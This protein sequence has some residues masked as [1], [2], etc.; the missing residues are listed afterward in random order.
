M[1]PQDDQKKGPPAG[2]VLDQDRDYPEAA[3][4]GT[5]RAVPAQPATSGWDTAKRALRFVA[6]PAMRAAY[7]WAA[8]DLPPPR[9]P[10]EERPAEER[11]REAPAA[12]P[13][14]PAKPAAAP[15][16][17][18]G[19]LE[20]TF[21]IAA[22]QSGH[23]LSEAQKEA[24]RTAYGIATMH[25]PR[26]RAEF[27]AEYV[28][29][30]RR[31]ARE[32]PPGAGMG[33]RMARGAAAGL[34][35]SVGEAAGRGDISGAVGRAVGQ[36][37]AFGALGELG[38]GAPEGPAP[39]PAPAPATL[40]R[41]RGGL[42][43]VPRVTTADMAGI[44]ERE[45]NRPAPSATE[46][47]EAGAQGIFRKPYGQLTPEQQR[48]VARGL[49][50]PPGG[51]ERRT[52]VGEAPTA[53][54]RAG[55]M[56][57]PTNAPPAGAPAFTIEERGGIR[58]AKSPGV[59]DVSI[60]PR[61]TDPAQVAA[62]VAE[63]QALQRQG[64]P[65]LGG[66]GGTLTPTTKAAPAAPAA[67]PGVPGTLPRIP[68]PT[69]LPAGAPA[70][71]P[72]TLDEI[73]RQATGQA[74]PRKPEPGKPLR[75]Q[76]GVTERAPPEEDPLKREFP[77]PATRR[78]ARANGAELLRT[79]AAL[80]VLQAVHDLKNW[81]IRQ[82]AINA[83]IDVGTKH[84]GSRM[85]LGA[86]QVARQDLIDQMIRQGVPPE[87]I[88]RLAK[89]EPV[90][91][92]KLMRI[93]KSRLGPIG[94]TEEALHHELGHVIIGGLDGFEQYGIAS[95]HHPANAGRM[96]TLASAQFRI[97]QFRDIRGNFDP[98]LLGS[99]IDRLLDLF[100]AGAAA[101]EVVDGIPRNENPGLYGDKRMAGELFD[102]L[103]L[104]AKQHE[105]YWNAAVDR[106]KER[107]LK[108]GV[109]DL[110][111]QEAGRR[112]ENLPV[113]FHFSKNRVA[114]IIDRA[115]SL[116]GE[117]EQLNLGFAAEGPAAGGRSGQEVVTGTEERG[118][119]A[120]RGGAFPEKLKPYSIPKNTYTIEIYGGPNTPREITVQAVTRRK[121]FEIAQKQNPGS[122][123]FRMKSE[124]PPEVQSVFARRELPNVPPELEKYLEPDEIEFL[125]G[126]PILQRNMVNNYRGLKPSL[127]EAATVARA[128]HGLGG[129]WQRFIDT[130]A[131]LGEPT[132]GLRDLDINHIEN[133]K[134][135]HGALS[136]NK[137]VEQANRI[138]WGAYRDWL[139]AGRPT[140][141]TSIN[142]IVRDNRGASGRGG[143][144]TQKL[145]K[146]VNSPQ[147][148][149]GAPF[150]GEAFMRSPV[151]GVSPGAKK[152]PSMVATTAGRGNL[153][154]VVFD[155]HMKDLYGINELTDAQYLAASIHIRQTGEALGYAAGE[156][157]E[158]MWG[159]VLGLKELMGKG[160]SPR[161]AAQ[162]FTK[163]AIAAVSK[164][165]ARVIEESIESDPEMR[166]I[167]DD[168][169]K[170]G[171]DPGGPVASEQ[172]R[173]IVEAGAK[174]MA[175]RQRPI[176]RGFLEK[177]ARRISRSRGP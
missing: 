1:P 125:R 27:Q 171:F 129:W 38:R 8:K 117:P 5:A 156:A 165:Y 135:F 88:P 107:L 20:K 142:R 80:E 59:N 28:E 2:F 70:V 22:Q 144:D 46:Q 159:T 100:A 93:P 133:L 43:P 176:S 67:A 29:P 65:S 74:E 73:L 147:L 122:M 120:T 114:H 97:G 143:L 16:G 69:A 138:A 36:L 56:P 104:P 121:A 87:E 64:V 66:A 52:T 148:K 34:I 111:R 174:R 139:E 9:L 41:T 124:T 30:F 53:E 168:L 173:Q 166:E 10:A 33:E 169:K 18:Q 63:K 14:K 149:E 130:F 92:Q 90:G 150:T 50:G 99:R 123:E 40:P 108:P 75:G 128:G 102:A 42:P 116:S 61:L 127:A 76:P 6:D 155:T 95:H 119:A 126:R 86:E 113:E 62:Y 77:D 141:L 47:L 110:I 15:R 71:P 72:A 31:A 49:G 60:P 145:F 51:V 54:R 137:A 39:A 19:A 177:A 172:L 136:G 158:Q 25:L 55:A 81:E 24:L 154:R 78:L 163:Q 118:A 109:A 12:A 170:F 151:A 146:L 85:A 23:M 132:E 21:D 164:D 32:T 58:W 35:P 131:A 89:T 83:G 57:L 37:G 103:E 48:V 115:R 162:S 160:L 157:Q 4:A 161:Q 106:A 44:L 134:A 82:A 112:E 152:I 17:D 140:D 45:M 94:S 101:G 26:S 91:Y 3:P 11:P 105:E 68:A 84:V 79:G 167:M 153:K 98:D 175:E 96:G 13:T 7:S